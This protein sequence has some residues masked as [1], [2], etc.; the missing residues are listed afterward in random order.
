MEF[1]EDITYPKDR[2]ATKPSL[3]DIKDVHA[4]VRVEN[5]GETITADIQATATLVLE[6]AYTLEPLERR[7]KI[8]E[9]VHFSE[10]VQDDDELLYAP[11]PTIDLDDYLFGLIMTEVPAKVVKRG[12]HLPKAG[13]G[14]RVL[15][16][17]ELIREKEKNGDPR[18]SE[19]DKFEE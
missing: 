14:Y 10:T 7:I 19:L 9:E 6:C 13:K 18:F 8:D 16:E 12:A 17:A 5:F 11:G 15:N 2:M 4:K 1:E 3:L